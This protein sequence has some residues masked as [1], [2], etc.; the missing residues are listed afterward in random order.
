[1]QLLCCT[2]IE[3]TRQYNLSREN[4]KKNNKQY[5]Q[6]SIVLFIHFKTFLLFQNLL[7]GRYKERRA[8]LWIDF[9]RDF[10]MKGKKCG[11]PIE[12]MVEKRCVSAWF[13]YSRPQNGGQAVSCR[14]QNT[15]RYCI[16]FLA[17]GSEHCYCFAVVL[18][19][20]GDV[21]EFNVGLVFVRF[22]C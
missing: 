11:S 19:Q 12:N 22:T 13:I 20:H 14:N 9:R 4:T 6:S 10:V 21:V 17:S 2:Q 1:M 15:C 3:L 16:A 18:H 7:R 5:K 8:F